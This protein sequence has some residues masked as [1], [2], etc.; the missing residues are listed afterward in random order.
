MR[1]NP[2]YF[3]FVKVKFIKFYIHIFVFIILLFSC[4]YTRCIKTTF[5]SGENMVYFDGGIT[6]TASTLSYN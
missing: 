1:R 4:L 3:E 2:T 5:Y 6:D